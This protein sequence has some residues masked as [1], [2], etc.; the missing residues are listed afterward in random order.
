MGEAAGD[1][2]GDEAGGFGD[3][4]GELAGG[5]WEGVGEVAGAPPQEARESARLAVSVR[6][7]K[8]RMVLFL[9]RWV[10]DMVLPLSIKI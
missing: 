4:A 3:V 7:V 1:A 5:F 2:A 6:M 10:K 9:K 8:R